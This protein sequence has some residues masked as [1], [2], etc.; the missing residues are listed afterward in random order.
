MRR[1]MISKGTLISVVI[2]H[3]NQPAAL[4]ACLSSL[5][6]QSLARCFFEIIVVDNGSV[7][8]PEDIVANHAG[9]RLLCE[10]QPGPGPARN[11]GVRSATGDII[12]FIDADCRAHRDWL[13]NALQTI[14]SLPEGT[15]L[16]G[17]VRIWRDRLNTSSAIEAYE[18]VFGYRFKLFIER[19][20]YCGTGNL[21]VRRTDYDKAG[22]FAGIDIAEDVEW[23]QRARSAGLTFRYVPEMIVFHPARRSLQE[24]CV[25]WDRHTQHNLNMARGKRGWKI[26]WIT[27]ALAVL[28]SPVVDSLKALGS[29]RIQGVST[30]LKAISVLFAIR[31]YRARRMLAL[32]SASEVVEWNRGAAASA[33]IP[34]QTIKD[35]RHS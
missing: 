5:D 11:L 20:G 16:G 4:E 28:A 26:R 1:K 33:C 9:T 22:A 17:D 10:L 15:I 32:L 34:E 12:A 24:L 35:L 19:H 3:L 8:I 21:V 2:P 27:R 23:G 14:R 29:D 7:P 30:R 18:G 25:K 31:A 6:A 13:R